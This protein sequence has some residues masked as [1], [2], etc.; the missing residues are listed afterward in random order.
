ML[1]RVTRIIEF[2]VSALFLD[3]PET[4]P[5]A[6]RTATNSDAPNP[7]AKKVQP[8]LNSANPRRGGYGEPRFLDN[9]AC[10]H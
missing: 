9:Q 6:G 2:A 5:M 3:P 7:F 10:F 4:M 1:L 8:S